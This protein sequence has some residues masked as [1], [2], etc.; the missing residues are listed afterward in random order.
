MIDVSELMSDPDFAQPY[1][2]ERSTG[3]S[4]PGGWQ[5]AVK[6]I[7]MYGPTQP[8]DAQTIQ[9]VPEGDRVYGARIFWATQPLYETRGGKSA[10]ISDVL[11]WQN[12]RFRII[13][14]WPWQDG[15]FYKA[16]AVRMEGN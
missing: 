13:A 3:V 5:G 10:G 11:I 9:M 8:A 15:G 2:V 6:P 14:V 12:Q 16:L 1:V 4:G 7:L